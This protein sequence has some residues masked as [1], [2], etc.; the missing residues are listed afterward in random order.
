MD[1]ATTSSTVARNDVLSRSDGNDA[2]AGGTGNEDY[3][4]N[5]S[6]DVIVAGTNGG[7]DTVA[8]FFR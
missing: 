1:R 5:D 8:I 7:V 2:M 6:D 4:I 3:L